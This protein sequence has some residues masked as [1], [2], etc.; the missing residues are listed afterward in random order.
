MFEIYFGTILTVSAIALVFF[1]YNFIQ[2]KFP[3]KDLRKKDENNL[4]DK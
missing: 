3:D 2:S 4:K 1:I